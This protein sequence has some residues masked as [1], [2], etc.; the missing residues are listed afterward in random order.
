MNNDETGYCKSCGES[1]S[2]R[3]RMSR[4]SYDRNICF[5]FFIVLWGVTELIGLNLDL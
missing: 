3:R 1:L 2:R 5:G 4:Q